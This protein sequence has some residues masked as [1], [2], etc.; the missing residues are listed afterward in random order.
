[1]YN[2][3]LTTDFAIGGNT[4]ASAKF[5]VSMSGTNPTA[6]VSGL[7]SNAAMIVDN[8][9]VGDLFTASKSGKTHF[10]IK[11]D[12]SSNI[13]NRNVMNFY[14]DNGATL[15]GYVGQ[16]SSSN[17]LA[18]ISKTTSAWLRLGAA[19]GG[20]VS[21]WTDGNAD[22]NTS[23]QMILNSAGRLGIGAGANTLLATLDVRAQ[24]TGSYTQPVASI[25]G[26]TGKATLTVDNSGGG[27]LFTA[28]SSGLSRFVIKQNG[29]VGIGTT[30]P[31]RTLDIAGEINMT[32]TQPVSVAGTGTN[33]IFS[34]LTGGKG[35]NTSGT[36]GQSA[37]QGATI[38]ITGGAGGDAPSGS[39]NGAGGAIFIDGGAQGVG[40][41]GGNFRGNVV[42]QQAGGQVG[43]GTLS[44][45]AFLHINGSDGFAS[46]LL[47]L[48]DAGS[49]LTRFEVKQIG[50]VGIGTTTPLATLDIR[51]VSGTLPIA[52]A[53]GQSS[54]AAMVVDNTG[55]G[56]LFTASKSGATKFTVLNNGNIRMANYN[57]AGGVFYGQADGTL[58]LSAATGS[59]GLC[60]QSNGAAAPS[61]GNCDNPSSVDAFQLANGLISNG[62]LT[63]DFAFGGNT[64]ASAKFKVSVSGTQPTA[65]VS[66][67][68][69]NAALIV[70]N[71][72]VGD[73]FTASKS[74]KTFFTIKNNGVVQ[75]GQVANG[76][77]TNGLSFDY[78]NGGPTY[79][80]TARPTK[81]IVLSPEYAG[82]ILTASDSAGVTGS[83]DGD[84]TADASASA[85][86]LFT[87]N[88]VA[89]KYQTYYEWNSVETTF[90]DYTVAVRVTLPA[91]FDSWRPGGSSIQVL[92]NTEANTATSNKLDMFLYPSTSSVPTVYRQG[93][94]SNTAA[95][96]WQTIDVPATDLNDGTP[97]NAASQSAILYFKMY[98][99]DSNYVQLGDI[100]LNYLSK[101]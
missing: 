83:H 101:F 26:Q 15:R 95:K 81:Q 19:T 91:D 79:T 80:G 13:Y 17:D 62:N 82:G 100:I 92:Y 29:N 8:A 57:T 44:P 18:L 77:V 69:S 50:T 55:L 67:S 61:W 34:A 12:G 2:G 60:L 89:Q 75:M 32:G 10:V 52:S 37:G 43:I 88:S 51:G 38:S 94:F 30:L 40:A 56:D 42:L 36:T 54:F 48:V 96:A 64:S 76:T 22:V 59:T 46:P 98:S 53:S 73:I 1:L 27:D 71:A 72:G 28:S 20:A 86:T 4:S 93:Q 58:G 63:T 97:W 31:T 74:G 16:E 23:P 11:N 14:N 78:I 25:S 66:G 70:D 65:S 85:G 41:G 49:T 6:S 5:L 90:Q 84:M 87:L 9:G 24:G 39:T 45:Q 68:T 7:T 21:F 47:K 33:A 3:N 35:G 99:K